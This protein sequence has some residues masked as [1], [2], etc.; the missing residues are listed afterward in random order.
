MDSSFREHGSDSDSQQDPKR[1]WMS[2]L[3]PLRI[4]KWLAALINLTEEEQR[5]AGVYLA[6]RDDE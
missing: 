1:S 4:I 3:I 2:L 6:R 5:D